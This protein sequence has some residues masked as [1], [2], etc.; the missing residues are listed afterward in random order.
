MMILLVT[1][2]LLVLLPWYARASAV[3]CLLGVNL[4][5]VYAQA[6]QILHKIQVQTYLAYSV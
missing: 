2:L 5:P 4:S 6:I 3:I 1:S